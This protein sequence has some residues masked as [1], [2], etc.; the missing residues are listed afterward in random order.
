MVR[1]PRVGR[2]VGPHGHQLAPAQP[3][4]PLDHLGGGQGVE[5]GDGQ[6]RH[7]GDVGVDRGGAAPASGLSPPTAPGRPAGAGRAR[8]RDRSRAGRL[9][10]IRD[11]AQAWAARPAGCGWLRRA[12]A[13]PRR[14][15]S[16][17]PPDRRQP[18]RALLQLLVAGLHDQ[19]PHGPGRVDLD[20]E[21]LPAP[22]GQPGQLLGHG[23]G[24]SGRAG[25]RTGRGTARS[26]AGRS[27]RARR[28]CRPWSAPLRRSRGRASSSCP[29]AGCRA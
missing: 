10:R 20:A 15:P 23:D 13:R 14:L 29:P 25:T 9:R 21:A 28:G 18:L 27:A 8:S 12:S 3:V 16:G 24:Q 19:V 17:R 22:L 2:L 1:R 6:R 7:V 4:E 26:A 5:P 11:G